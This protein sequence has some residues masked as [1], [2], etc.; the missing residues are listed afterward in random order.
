MVDPFRGVDAA[1]KPKPWVPRSAIS[2]SLFIFFP[3]TAGQNLFLLH[4]PDR[5][6]ANQQLE[7]AVGRLS[8]FAGQVKHRPSE[9]EAY[10][11]LGFRI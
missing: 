7:N 8:V 10:K 3:A 1:P 11:R 9:P 4:Y 2:Q 5:E 6:Y